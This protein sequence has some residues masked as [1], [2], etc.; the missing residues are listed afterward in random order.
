MMSIFKK[1]YAAI[2]SL[3]IA[4]T[5]QV[6]GMDPSTCCE[7]SCCDTEANRLSVYGGVLYWQ[8]ELCGL[9]GAFGDTT[10]ATSVGDDAIT[11]T[12]V[13]ETDKEPHYKWD[14]GYRVG[15]EAEFNCFDIDL[16]YTHFDGNANFRDGAQFGNWKIKYDTIDLT[17]GRYFSVWSCF[18]FKPYI[19]LRAIK[20]HQKLNSH[21]ETLF[22]SPLIGDNIVFTDK[23]DKED[24]R[25]IGP[26]IGIK[27]DWYIGCNFSLYGSFA[28]LTYYGEV[29]GKNFDVDTFTTTV[30]VCDGK[31]K[32]C[33]SNLATDGELGLR[34][35]TSSNCFCGC[36]VNFMLKLGVEQHRIYDFSN[37][38]SDGNL[39]LY[40]GVFA[41]GIGFDY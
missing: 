3:F 13:F 28:F 32:R 18:D 36:D 24:F 4:V 25:G 8:P 19:G 27:A 39:S 29:D 6:N 40:G 10:I 41:A 34:W 1:K 23:H 30:S 31:I 14:V 17:F 15:A 38:G 9:E 2:L 37:L 35:A 21:L 26:Q 7:S 11:T 12:T 33:F 20:V 22:T 5:S 16:Y